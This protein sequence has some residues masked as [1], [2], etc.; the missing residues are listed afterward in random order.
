[1]RHYTSISENRW[2]LAPDG[3]RHQWR[4][5]LSR[6]TRIRH[7]VPEACVLLASFDAGA[8]RWKVAFVTDDRARK[9]RGIPD[10]DEV[11]D[12]SGLTDEE[13]QVL[14]AVW[15]SVT[16]RQNAGTTAGGRHND[17][18]TMEVAKK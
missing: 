5:V 15:K 12:V 16:E 8:C 13:L 2:L 4:F 3:V 1:M 9:R 11:V 7:Y 18:G 14:L 6:L 17:V 10:Q